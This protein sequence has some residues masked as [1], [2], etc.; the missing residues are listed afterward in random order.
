MQTYLSLLQLQFKFISNLGICLRHTKCT[1]SRH[2]FSNY[3]N[4]ICYGNCGDLQ[5]Q[6]FME[7][8][9][10]GLHMTSAKSGRGKNKG[11][12]MHKPLCNV[13]HSVINLQ[14]IYGAIQCMNAAVQH[15]PPPPTYPCLSSMTRCTAAH[16][17]Y[18]YHAW[19]IHL[20]TFRKN[21]LFQF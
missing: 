6:M 21:W 7:N 4:F 17:F 15:Y 12:V 11:V 9:T 13:L 18:R 19:L 14:Y 8:V 20:L 2:N 10:R 5:Y 3:Q 1:G 16:L